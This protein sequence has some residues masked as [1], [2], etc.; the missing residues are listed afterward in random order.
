MGMQ[1]MIRRVSEA[2]VGLGEARGALEELRLEAKA[3]NQLTPDQQFLRIADALRGVENQSDRVRLAF[4]LFDSEGVAL[5]QTLQHGS[6]AIRKWM[7]EAE[8][9]GATFTGEEA[10]E[11]EKLNDALTKLGASTRGLKTQILIDISPTATKYIDKLSESVQGFRLTGGEDIKP[12]RGL[13]GMFNLGPVMDNVR[14]IIDERTESLIQR[15]IRRGVAAGSEH[16]VGGTS[17]EQFRLP[18][19][20][21]A[22]RAAARESDVRS[23]QVVGFLRRQTFDRIQQAGG[24]ILDWA[25]RLPEQVEKLE[26]AGRSWALSDLAATLLGRGGGTRE[27]FRQQELAKQQLA[28]HQQRQDQ[29][30][31]GNVINRALEEGTQSAFRESLANITAQ[32]LAKQELAEQKKQTGHLQQLVAFARQAPEIQMVAIPL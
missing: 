21:H 10:A 18:G 31:L 12:L 26:E 16:Q 25:K 6:G 27:F 28:Q 4:K 32:P 20:I 19:R 3:L 1:R 2:A 9:I 22:P 5:V 23:Q 11:V 13:A 17:A 15:Q 8:R 24:H 30:T 14:T 7:D 29:R